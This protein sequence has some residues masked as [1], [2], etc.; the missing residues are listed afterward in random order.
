MAEIRLTVDGREVRAPSGAT[1]LEAA[2]DAGVYIPT[3]CHHPDLPPAADTPAAEAVYQ[4]GR[5][6]ENVRPGEGGSGCGLCVVEVGGRDDLVPACSTEAAEGMVVSTN[7]ARVRERRR[8]NLVPILAGHPHACLTC[9]QQDGCSRSHCSVNVPEEER[10]CPRFGQCEL[11]DVVNH[12][13]VPDVTPRW[14]PTRLPVEDGPLFVRDPNLCIGCTRCVRACRDLRGVEAIGFVRDEQGR[15]RVGSLARDLRES[16][17]RFCTACVEVCPTGALTDKNVRPGRKAQDLVPCREACPAG[18]DVPGYVRRVARKRPG[19]AVDLI[20]ETVP[21]PGVLGRVCPRPCEDACRRGELDEP[22]AICAL[23]RYAADAGKGPGKQAARPGRST[24]KRVAVIGAGPAGLS[25]AFYLRRAGHGV[26]LYEAGKRAGGTMRIIPPFRL[27]R[28]V[29]EREVQEILD[30]GVVFRPGRALGR[31]LGLEDLRA[32]GFDA[33]FLATGAQKGRRV[34]VEGADLPG[35]L[36]GLDYLRKAAEG[37][38]TDQGNRV[39]VIGGGSVAVDVARTALRLGAGRVTVACLEPRDGMPAREAEVEALEDEGA[40][41]MPSWGVERILEDRGR[42]GGADLV[43][44]TGLFDA[45]GAFRPSFDRETR[46]R[47]SA[48]RVVFAVGQDPELPFLEEEAVGTDRGLIVVDPGTQET[49]APGL[50]AGGD[51]AAAS[52]T[53]VHA[54]AAGRRAA[55]AVDRALGGTG[56]LGE[57]PVSRESPDPRPGREEGFADRPR[58]PVPERDPGVRVADFDEVERGYA[59]DAAAREASRCLQCDL[60]LH[61]GRNP[62]PPRRWLPFE[63]ASLEQVPEAEG[64][65]RLMN[66]DCN[67][68]AIRGT[69]DLSRSLREELEEGGEAALFEFEV[70]RMYSKRESELLQKYVREHGGMPGEEDLDDLF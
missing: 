46:T 5:R 34:P 10:C 52:G 40:E 43:R 8:Q 63:R 24:G 19:D 39:L 51:A 11:Q 16:G 35:V 64:V 42:V 38:R 27:P 45:G 60:R 17:C 57:G 13:G 6:I 15:V 25:A 23:K 70:D 3:L 12:L 29:L 36:P 69:A 1:I 30:I 62:P 48:D 28:E 2:R 55:A 58:M 66:A 18:V 54:A 26:T 68:L 33:V 20:R 41:L 4:G 47:L 31:D 32:D 22:V 9:A 37:M 14:V 53:V 59:P 65:Y 56:D 7:T 49:G 67:V 21:F 61:M 44:C 50:Y